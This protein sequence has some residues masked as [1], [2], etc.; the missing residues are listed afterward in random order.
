MRPR[1]RSCLAVRKPSRPRT[2]G[3]CIPVGMRP[4]E[5]NGMRRVCG[6]PGTQPYLWP[7]PLTTDREWL[8]RGAP[9]TVVALKSH[10]VAAAR[11]VPEE[12]H[13][14]P[15]DAGLADLGPAA[16]LAEPEEEHQ[17]AC[18]GR[19]GLERNVERAAGQCHAQVGPHAEQAVGC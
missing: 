15:A 11:E 14:G 8:A 19:G 3:G 16:A 4:T 1:V 5:D 2:Q 12:D 10:V 17:L 9:V 18:E 6:P 7:R 13:A